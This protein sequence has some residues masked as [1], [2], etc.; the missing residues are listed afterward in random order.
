MGLLKRHNFETHRQMF[1]A[2]IYEKVAE[3][4]LCHD[5]E[6]AIQ[7]ERLMDPLQ[8]LGNAASIAILLSIDVKKC[9]YDCAAHVTFIGNNFL[10]TTNVNKHGETKNM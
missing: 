4:L 6:V 2:V 3:L 1:G 8:I 7:L 5:K 9:G 10:Y